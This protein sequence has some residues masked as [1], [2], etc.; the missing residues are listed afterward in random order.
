MRFPH[1][2]TQPFAA[3]PERAQER[4]SR[5]TP[6]TQ[7]SRPRSREHAAITLALQ[8]KTFT[9]VINEPHSSG[10]MRAPGAHGRERSASNTP[11]RSPQPE[12]AHTAPRREH[13]ACAQYK[14][15]CALIACTQAHRKLA[16]PSTLGSQIAARRRSGKHK[17]CGKM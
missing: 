10:T 4:G 11:K 8:N 2:T 12:R 6:N 5:R 1:I 3:M 9:H 16:M 14:A 17:Y 7:H 15:R 13:M